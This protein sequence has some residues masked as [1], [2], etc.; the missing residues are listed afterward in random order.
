MRRFLVLVALTL[1]I[2]LPLL[3]EAQIQRY[4]SSIQGFSFVMESETTSV[5]QLSPEQPFDPDLL[6]E[7]G[8]SS[9]SRWRVI[10][11]TGSQIQMEIYDVLDSSG[12]FQLFS[13]WPESDLRNVTLDLPI[14]AQLNPS[15]GIF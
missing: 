7:A 6:K 12:A 11:Q 5:E 10:P 8:F 14:S 1:V 2:G 9:F 15:E 3:A 13:H 4:L